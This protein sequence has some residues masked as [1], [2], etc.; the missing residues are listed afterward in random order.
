M[1]RS[2][3]KRPCWTLRLGIAC[4]SLCSLDRSKCEV[5]ASEIKKDG[6]GRNSEHLREIAVHSEFMDE[7]QNH[8]EIRQIGDRNHD[9]ETRDAREPSAL[10]IESPAAIEQ[11]AD[12][13]TQRIAAEI[14]REIAQSAQPF[15]KPGRQQPN[16]GVYTAD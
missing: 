1:L 14:R 3:R 11:E 6:I 12:A 2:C 10:E 13:Y 16:A 9:Q 4:C 8:A 7:Q 15:E 5:T